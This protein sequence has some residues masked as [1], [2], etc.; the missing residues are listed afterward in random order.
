M[1]A[2]LEL[3]HRIGAVA[4]DTDAGSPFGVEGDGAYSVFKFEGGTH[5]VQRVPEDGVPGRI[6]TSTATVAVLPEAEDVEV[7]ID[8][9]D[10]QIDV[11]RSLRPRWPVGEHHPFVISHHPQAE[12][13]R[14]LHAG[15]E[16]PA[17]EPGAGDARAARAA[18]RAGPG[19]AAGR[20]RRASRSAQ[21][22]TGERAEKIRTYNYRRARVKDHRIN[23]LVHNLDEILLGELDEVTDALQDDEKR[24]Q[25]QE[26]TAGEGA[27]LRRRWGLPCAGAARLAARAPTV[28]RLDAE[29]LLPG[30]SWDGDRGRLVLDRDSRCSF[31]GD[32]NQFEALLA[33]PRRRASRS[34]M[35]GT[36]R[37]SGSWRLPVDR[38]VLIPRPETELRVEAGA[39]GCPS[40]AS[41]VDV[42]T[43]SGAVALAL[44]DERP[45]PARLG[46]DV[47]ADA[48]DV[49][50]A[51]ASA[52]AL[53][54]KFSCGDLL[55]GCR[56]CDAV[57]ANLPY[58]RRRRRAPARCRG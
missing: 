53:D 42:G 37:H 48:I 10:L 40:G 15:R 16:I 27:P 56:T 47:S 12:R 17:S 29:L 6:H 25:L 2:A 46:V 30:S 43:G 55:D 5:R 38:R 41:A 51:N 35:C 45:R 36:A 1:G 13:P 54:V 21:V 58:V 49:A 3:E 11:Y 39:G 33:T 9:N 20:A 8:P 7:E 28:A 34:P 26:R 19:R 52:L 44:E 57:L 50:R 4:L 32:R 24:R 23:L 31:A 14:R 22:G 18:V